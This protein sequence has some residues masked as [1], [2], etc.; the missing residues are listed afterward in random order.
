MIPTVINGQWELLLPEHRA[1]RAEWTSD[2]GWERERLDS[3][4]AHIRPG[5]LV[6]DIGT[7]EGDLSA[8]YAT[9]VGPEGGVCLFEPTDR[10]WPNVRAIFEANGLTSRIKGIWAGFASD[11]TVPADGRSGDPNE[12]RDGWPVSAYGPVIGD[13]GFSVIVERPDFPQVRLDDYASERGLTPDVITMDVEGAE[14][15]VVRGA[16]RILNEVRPLL[17]I[18]EHPQFMVDT[19]GDSQADLHK[20]V[21]GCGYRSTLLA[22]DHEQH[23]FYWPEERP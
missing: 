23:H 22:T 3:M 7:E 6:F 8:L 9:W 12:Q 17:W 14:L 4:H 19:F 21:E 13:H 2:A 1:A 10:T 18:S 20:F 11:Q 5:D 15:R 16:E